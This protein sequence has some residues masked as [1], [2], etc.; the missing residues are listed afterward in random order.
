MDIYFLITA[1]H[2]KIQRFV[3]GFPMQF[4]HANTEHIMAMRFFGSRF[5]IIFSM[6]FISKVMEDKDSFD[7]CGYSDGILLV[8][9]K[10]VVHCLEK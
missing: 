8:L 4:Q 9:I 2:P 10:G 6:S 1:C 3:N 5:L 7:F